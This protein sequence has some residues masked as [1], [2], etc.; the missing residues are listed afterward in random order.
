MSQLTRRAFLTTTA[1]GAFVPSLLNA[2]E[3]ASQTLTSDA[4][5]L[6]FFLV[7]DT[8]YLADR[9]SPQQLA[10]ASKTTNGRLIERLNELPGKPIDERAGGGRV[11]TPAGVIHAG[12][13]IDSGDKTGATEKTMQ[14]TEL[15]AF[16]NDY[17]LTGKEGKLRYPVYEVHGN[18]DGPRGTGPVV[19]AIKDRNRKRSGVNHVSE[20]GLHYAWNW[21]DVRFV[22]LGIVVGGVSPPDRKRRYDPLDSLAF[23]KDD[24]AKNVGKSGKPVV[25]VHHIDV[26]RYSV[27][28][29]PETPAGQAEW[30]SCDVNAYH[31]ALRDYHVAAVLYGHTHS[32][33]IF[34]WDGTKMPAES[35]IPTFNNDNSAHFASNTQGLLYFEMS[36]KELKVRELVTADRWQT[37]AWTQEFW[38]FPI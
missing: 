6:A 11:L 13:L 28:C 3:R 22:C 34:R 29:V 18:H 14:A 10:E 33:K 7:G 23:L 32:R 2:Q 9:T 35:G 19:E 24:L 17:G 25:I 5:P 20:N 15:T 16:I 1:A 38:S 37:T 31:A 12:D 21:G 27:D 4:Q 36:A 8:H 26:L 30:D